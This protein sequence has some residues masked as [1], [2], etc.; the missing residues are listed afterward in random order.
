MSLCSGHSVHHVTLL[1]TLEVLFRKKL[2]VGESR[3]CNDR[4]VLNKFW[5]IDFWHFFWFYFEVHFLAVVNLR[6]NK[7][8]IVIEDKSVEEAS[9]IY[10]IQ[11]INIL[12]AYCVSGPVLN[13]GNAKISMSQYL[14]LR[15][16][17]SSRR[18]REVKQ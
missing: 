10:F 2:P 7:C 15:R 18:D 6:Y 8:I 16:S 9:F 11:A 13:L 3:H 14:S 1:P 17:L 5:L 4:H 12:N